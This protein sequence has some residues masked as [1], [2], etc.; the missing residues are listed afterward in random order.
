MALTASEAVE[1]SGG[2]IV[3]DESDPRWRDLGDNVLIGDN[4]YWLEELEVIKEDRFPEF[5]IKTYLDKNGW[6]AFGRE[7]QEKLDTLEHDD[8][9]GINKLYE[10]LQEYE[11]RT[12]IC[13]KPGEEAISEGELSFWRDSWKKNRSCRDSIEEFIDRNY[14]E[15]SLHLDGLDDLRREYGEERIQ[16]VLAVTVRE[17]EWDGRYSTSNKEWAKRIPVPEGASVN[18]GCTLKTHPGLVDLFTSLWREELTKDSNEFLKKRFPGTI[19][20]QKSPSKEDAFE[21]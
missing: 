4:R 13:Y 1:Q 6:L 8:Q 17:Y 7:L 3:Q 20:T 11:E 14:W 12:K 16:V 19:E 21:R 9:A 10:E 5:K 2:E 18:R 15:N